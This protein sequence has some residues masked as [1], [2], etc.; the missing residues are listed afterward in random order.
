MKYMLLEY[1]YIKQNHLQSHTYVLENIAIVND[2]S[3]SKERNAISAENSK[4]SRN[5]ISASVVSLNA[6]ELYFF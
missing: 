6:V 5:A 3:V 4:V 1:L 2:T